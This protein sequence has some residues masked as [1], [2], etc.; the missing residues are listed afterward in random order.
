MT[1]YASDKALPVNSYLLNG[2]MSEDLDLGQE[3]LQTLG[4]EQH[5]LATM[6]REGRIGDAKTKRDDGKTKSVLSAL[7]QLPGVILRY[8][9]LVGQLPADMVFLVPPASLVYLHPPKTRRERKIVSLVLVDD[10]DQ[11]AGLKRLNE[12]LSFLKGRSLSTLVK[13]D[14]EDE[15]E[16]GDSTSS[17]ISL[18][19][20]FAAVLRPSGA[21]ASASAM[22]I[23]AVVDALAR[24]DDD[25][26]VAFLHS[27]VSALISGSP[28]D[29]LLVTATATSAALG[30]ARSRSDIRRHG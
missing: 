8:H 23:Q 13:A 10:W 22:K 28:L 9:Q 16:D 15:D 4:K 25:A 20:R 12:A 17:D 26:S 5:L 7:M 1:R 21:A 18:D 2:L 27:L 19:S 11:K 30:L 6:L 24:S 29:A 14:E 3:L